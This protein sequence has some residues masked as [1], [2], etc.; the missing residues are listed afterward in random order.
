M[1]RKFC[2]AAILVCLWASASWAAEPS[3]TAFKQLTPTTRQTVDYWAEQLPDRYGKTEDQLE[4]YGDVTSWLIARTPL[5][6]AEEIHRALAAHEELSKQA[7]LSSPPREAT[8]VLDKLVQELPKRMRPR[9]FEYS[10]QVID[11]PGRQVFTVGAGRIYISHDYLMSILADT[12]YGQDRLTFV[13]AH[14]MGHICRHH[15]RHGYQTQWLQERVAAKLDDKF[16]HPLQAQLLAH[17]SE[18]SFKGLQ[19][20]YNSEHE[21]KADL[22]AIHLCRNAGFDVETCIDP[23]RES[24]LTTYPKLLKPAVETAATKEGEQHS[25]IPIASLASGKRLKKLREEMDGTVTGDDYG[26]F[27][28]DPTTGETNALHNGAVPQEERVLIFLHGL[29]SDPQIFRKMA[30]YL[31]AQQPLRMLAFRHPNDGSVARCGKFLQ[32]EIERTVASPERSIFVCHSAGG[33]VF[34]WYAEV[35]GGEFDRALLLGTPN[36]GSDLAKLRTVLEAKQFVGDFKLGYN[37][38]IERVILDSKGLIGFDLQ[39][40]SLLLRYLNRERTTNPDRRSRYTIIR[41]RALKRR[42]SLLA[43]TSFAAGRKILKQITVKK[44]TKPEVREIANRWIK[45]LSV[46]HE[47]SR[48]DLAV[49]LDSALLEGVN[50]VQTVSVNHLKLPSDPEILKFVG[51]WLVNEDDIPTN[52]ANP[53]PQ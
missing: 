23:L 44:I 10:L 4:F 36:S 29:D 8:Q 34:R 47:V 25:D 6:A 16:K 30:A 41:G 24:L 12:T 7:K 38:A 17:L 46:P 37:S 35:E 27:E 15:T 45:Q 21:Y 9:G 19:I 42:Y 5:P 20:L 2:F 1:H 28:M 39:P 13:L 50:D 40:E 49:T 53:A 31:A 33:L 22:F 26:L 48:G 3:T 18:S 43:D 51:E 52:A 11:K 14:E 32:R